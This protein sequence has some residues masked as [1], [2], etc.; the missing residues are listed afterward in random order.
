MNF[1]IANKALIYKKK[2]KKKM[3]HID[4]KSIATLDSVLVIFWFFR[5][6]FRLRQSSSHCIMSHGVVN[7][8]GRNGNVLILP[9]PTPIPWSLWLHLRLRF[10]NFTRTKAPFFLF[11]FFLCF[12]VCIWAFSCWP[13]FY[14]YWMLTD[15]NWLRMPGSTGP[16][17]YSGQ[18]VL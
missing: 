3:I 13:V 7:G 16:Y 9:T 2:K 10:S 17:G 11:Y 14:F 4:L 15:V 5:F 18:L 8:I 12:C 6:C 1:C